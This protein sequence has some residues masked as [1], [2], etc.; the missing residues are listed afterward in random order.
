[1]EVLKHVYHPATFPIDDAIRHAYDIPCS[2]FV[3][4]EERETERI[5]GKKRGGGD[6][7]RAPDGGEK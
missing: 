2:V 7:P 6:C 3:E 5:L 4:T 1:M